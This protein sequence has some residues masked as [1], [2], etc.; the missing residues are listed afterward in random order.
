MSI[1]LGNQQ[2]LKQYVGSYELGKIYLGD[3]LISD[4]IQYPNWI[5]ASSSLV[6]GFFDTNNNLTGSYNNTTGDWAKI[7]GSEAAN[8]T[9][10]GTLK[11]QVYDNPD[12]IKSIYSNSTSSYFGYNSNDFSGEY[13]MQ[14]WIKPYTSSNDNY[15]YRRD[16]STN[17]INL[18]FDSALDYIYWGMDTRPTPRSYKLVSSSID[19]DIW[20]GQW[21][22]IAFNY[23]DNARKLY[24][25][26]VLQEE[27]VGIETNNL[28]FSSDNV[29][30]GYLNNSSKM[31]CAS[32]LF[33]DGIQVNTDNIVLEN[34]N[35]SKNIFNTV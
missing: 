14:F 32:I 6:T 2:I 26:G 17:N 10:V 28:V 34:Y 1:N 24:V 20:N 13:L 8:L 15:I 33:Y 3:K 27:W 25:N 18:Y 35:N 19:P 9:R 12:Y 31:D 5:P 11:N 30:L 4:K 7:T 16:V 22:N 23:T 21:N 29:F